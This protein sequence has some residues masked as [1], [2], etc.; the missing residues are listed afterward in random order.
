VAYRLLSY[1]SADGPRAGIAVGEHVFD[2]QKISGRADFISVLDILN[3]WPA[4]KT[5]LRAATAQP[6]VS[7]AI[8]IADTQLLAPVLYPSA[9]YC[10]GA[11]YTDHV[12]NMSR[13]LG[14]EPDPD[15]RTLGLNPWFFLKA[16]R[17]T[18]IGHAACV[19]LASEKMDWEAELALVIGTK[20]KNV[21][22]E[23]AL[24]CVAGYTIGN[25]LSARDLTRRPHIADTSPF[26]YD[27]IGQKNFDGACPIG[28]WIV[29]AEDVDDP[30]N[31]SIKLWIN[32]VLKQDSST[33]RM[34][35]TAAEQISYLSSRITLYPG[36]IILTGTPAG[37]GAERDEFLNRGDKIRIEIEKVGELATAIV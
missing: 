3:N 37:V 35:F 2:A 4:A 23:R 17:S 13:R 34:I 11:N 1:Q 21:P 12:I 20:T 7:E 18:V 10:A 24:D 6:N 9:I 36:D 28:P 27:W 26:K 31:L 22:I 33:Q 32:D 16:A 5:I 25:D 19:P 8:G 29:P 14:L 30:Q 15:P